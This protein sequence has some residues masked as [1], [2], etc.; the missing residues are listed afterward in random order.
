MRA[1]E[2]RK[3]PKSTKKLI[4]QTD[5]I[6]HAWSEKGVSQARLNGIMKGIA[7]DGIINRSEAPYWRAAGKLGGTADGRNARK[8]YKMDT[9]NLSRAEV[10]EL[11]NYAANIAAHYDAHKAKKARVRAILDAHG[12]RRAQPPPPA[13]PAPAPRRRRRGGDAEIIAAANAAG[14]NLGIRTTRSGREH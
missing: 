8:K 14:G 13:Q 4:R 7:V 6:A 11:Q 5:L 3:D 1:S 9:D 2:F 10:Q 12:P